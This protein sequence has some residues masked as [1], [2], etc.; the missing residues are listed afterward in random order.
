[1]PELTDITHKRLLVQ[2]LST[3]DTDALMAAGVGRKVEVDGVFGQT[4]G[5]A[6]Y[7]DTFSEGR[8]PKIVMNWIVQVLF[9]QLAAKNQTFTGNPN[10]RRVG[11]GALS[12][13]A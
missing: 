12:H 6:T 4:G 10:A 2:G 9:G 13:H 5:V 1:M 7:F 8:D 3:Q 11:E